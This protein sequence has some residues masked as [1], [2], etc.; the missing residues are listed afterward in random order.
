ME[1][2]SDIHLEPQED[3]MTVRMRIDGILHPVLAVP[4]SMQAAVIARIKVMAGM[5]ITEHRLPQDGG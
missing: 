3:Q 4:S 5:N 2:A 1:Q